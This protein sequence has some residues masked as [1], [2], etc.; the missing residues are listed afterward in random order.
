MTEGD[1]A[2]ARAGDAGRKQ[3]GDEDPYTHTDGAREAAVLVLL[4]TACY[5]NSL[6]GEF[7]FDDIIA[8]ME[9][10]DVRPE[11]P[12]ATIFEAKFLKSSIYSDLK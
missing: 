1:A 2:P 9:N 7:V 5:L 10:K 11:T 8:V 6:W 4:S 3:G 12:L